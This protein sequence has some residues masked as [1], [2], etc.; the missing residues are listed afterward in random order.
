MEDKTL[1]LMYLAEQTSPDGYEIK[2]L[3]IKEKF[4]CIY[5]R[6]LAIL[7][8]FDVLNRNRRMYDGDNVWQCIQTN[9]RIQDGLRKKC[10]FGEDDHPSQDYTNMQLTAER[11]QKI[12][13]DRIS[14]IIINPYRDKNLL[15]SEIETYSGT[16]HGIGMCRSIIQ[17]CVPSFSCRSIATMQYKNGKPY[18]LVRRVITYDWV[19]YPSHK[20]AEMISKPSISDGVKK[21]VLESASNP[22]RFETKTYS[23]DVCIPFNE[24]VDFRD[25]VA[26]EDENTSAILE[27]GEYHVDDIVGIDPRTNNLIIESEGSKLFVNTNLK[28]KR[29]V[30]DFLS[31]FEL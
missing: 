3:D 1:A 26:E 5:A 8:S 23:N 9:D 28:T 20:E 7:H 31:S 25:Y 22:S 12:D 15:L 17:G 24:F 6:F 21:V 18:V 4:G 2:N 13:R 27:S 14:H 19:I 11:V 10:W 16:S 30:E 29:R